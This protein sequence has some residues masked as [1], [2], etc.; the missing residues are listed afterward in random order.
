MSF[1]SPKI[2]QIPENL[3]TF[4]SNNGLLCFFVLPEYY[5]FGKTK[6][7]NV[8]IMRKQCYRCP[9]G[10]TELLTQT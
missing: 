9:D 10:W 2:L 7:S 1:L 6:K 5:L 3:D 8:L 4:S